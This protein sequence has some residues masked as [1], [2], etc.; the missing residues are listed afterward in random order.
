[1]SVRAT[2]RRRT[3]RRAESSKALYMGDVNDIA[4]Q[5][6]DSGTWIFLTLGIAIGLVAMAAWLTH[7]I[8]FLRSLVFSRSLGMGNLLNAHYLAGR[9]RIHGP[10]RRGNPWVR[11]LG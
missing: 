4:A 9:D 7:S 5:A 2:D 6:S 10:H 3:K 8:W 11:D 1:M